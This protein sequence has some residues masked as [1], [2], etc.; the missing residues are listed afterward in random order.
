MAETATLA[1]GRVVWIDL[2]TKDTAAAETFYKG[3]FG[4]ERD[5]NPDP[6]F[7]GYGFFKTGGKIAAES[8]RPSQRTSRSSGRP[9]SAPR[10][11]TRR[12]PRLPAPAAP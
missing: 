11:P 6:Q 9:T 12:R 1:P 2:A 3:L 5:V 4:W 7:G 8:G 10:T